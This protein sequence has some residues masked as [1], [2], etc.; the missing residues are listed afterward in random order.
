MSEHIETKHKIKEIA[1]IST[2]E[3]LLQRAMINDKERQLMRLYYIENKTFMEIAEILGYE[4]P[5][6]KLWHKKV[7]KKISKII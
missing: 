1:E 2:F 6:M 7:L 3:S 4:E 5:T